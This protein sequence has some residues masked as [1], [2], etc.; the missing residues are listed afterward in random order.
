MGA[1]PTAVLRSGR[2]AVVHACRPL[3]IISRDAPP[4]TSHVLA[5]LVSP[6]ASLERQAAEL[7]EDEQAIEGKIRKKRAELD[8]NQKRLESLQSVRPAF[9]DEYERLEVRARRHLRCSGKR[10]PAQIKQCSAC[11]ILSSFV[12]HFLALRMLPH[13]SFI[14]LTPHALPRS[15]CSILLPCSRLQRELAD[16]Y[17]VYITKFRNLDYLQHE[18]DA[19]HRKEKESADASARALKKLQKRLKE[20][21]SR[22]VRG[23]EHDDEADGGGGGRGASPGGRGSSAL[24]G[25][26]PPAATGGPRPSISAAGQRPGAA[27]GGGRAPST[28]GSSGGGSRGSGVGGQLGPASSGGSA[29]GARVAAAVSTIRGRM[30]A[31]VDDDDESSELTDDDEEGDSRAAGGHNG[32][33]NDDGDD[34]EES[35]ADDDADF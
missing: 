30:N 26:R 21:E 5:L 34:E 15:L 13:P 10:S 19:F 3:I 33:E 12:S 25:G 18:L 27:V 16:E 23:D 6:A 9:M 28:A 32:P 7:G 17:E 20:E 8:R 29:G 35:D 24:G 22:L 31:P 11:C 14:H 2:R 1:A 4:L